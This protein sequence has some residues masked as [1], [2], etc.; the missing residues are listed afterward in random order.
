MVRQYKKVLGGRQYQRYST[1][2]V[3]EA[4]KS[5]RDGMSIR[6]AAEKFGIPK[7]TLQEHTKK[8]K[9]CIEIRKPGGQPVLST[10]EEEKL[11]E[12][13]MKCAEWGFPLR[14]REVAIVVQEYLNRSGKRVLKFKLNCPG[15]DWVETFLKRH[16]ILSTRLGEN[17]KRNRA[18][19]TREVI[20]DFFDKL[21]ISTANIPA[22][23]IINYD[24]TNFVDDPGQKKVRNTC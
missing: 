15:N 23:N 2:K 4:L 6:K 9:K 13:L 24:E 21:K 16:P 14:P 10:S 18:Q 19:V 7:S 17:I 20:S 8:H 3:N 12:G 11:V 22:S 5:I 1:E